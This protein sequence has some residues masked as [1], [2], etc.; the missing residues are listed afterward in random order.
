MKTTAKLT[1]AFILGT[2]INIAIVVF[3]SYF[4]TLVNFQQLVTENHQLASF[5]SSK[6][7]INT[8]FNIVISLTPF[9]LINSIIILLLIEHF[10]IHPF[11]KNI[12]DL[13]RFNKIMIDRELKMI[14][15]KKTIHA[16]IKKLN[17][18]D[19][20]HYEEGIKNHEIQLI[21]TERTQEDVKKALLNVLEDLKIN[22]TKIEQE[23]M[24]AEAILQSIG[25][26]M[27]AT[28]PNG[29]ITLLNQSA[30]EMFGWK[31][32]DA[33][34]NLFE[35]I[36]PV[37]YENNKPVPKN[38]NPI[39]VALSSGQKATTSTMHILYYTRKNKKRFPAAVTVTPVVIDKKVSGT[40]TIIRDTTKEKEIDRMKNEFISLASHQLRTPLSAIK[41][42][43]EM[44]L[45]GDA[46][47][48]NKDQMDLLKSVYQ[49][50]E[51]MIALVSSILNI[52]RIESG[53]IIIDPKPTDLVSLVKEILKELQVKLKEK[54]ISPIVS[55]HEKLPKINID[56][57]L[58][59]QVYINL[60]TN[61]IKYTPNSGE[62]SIF[63]SRKN[64]QIIS[65]IS[66]NGYGIPKKDQDKIFQK[67][68]RGENIVRIAADG[69]GLGLYLAKVILESS[70]GKIWFESQEGKG[71][72]FWF[73]LP[74][75]GVSP[76]E[77]EVTLDT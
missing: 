58:I 8:A 22:T 49:S 19:Q 44:L 47:T 2:I 73:S 3:L 62:V 30:E 14:T 61:A 11:E 33:I 42:F 6:F 68:F 36:I 60:L 18:D 72:T 74:I 37:T 51:R 54:N 59:R 57:K 4:L 41:W 63:L 31:S 7:A 34:G 56:P 38:D 71:T 21:Q 48:L 52:S 26:G 28:D 24:K 27:V 9:L 20:T 43:S 29:R 39:Y 50:N 45:D 13:E 65:Q 64:D 1:L 16:L 10:A 15:L 75:S 66:D 76:K 32:K 5:S 25:D 23:K 67:F 17:I 70:N 40:I 53:R 77:G 35:E 12:K 69:T 55:I 46:G